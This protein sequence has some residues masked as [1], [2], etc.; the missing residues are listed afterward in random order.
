MEMYEDL[1]FRNFRLVTLFWCLDYL[2]I[3]SCYD[4]LSA[5]LKHLQMKPSSHMVNNAHC[6][7]FLTFKIYSEKFLAILL[8][9]V[10]QRYKIL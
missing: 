10:I 3:V 5:S 9:L 7:L 4:F 8:C 2:Q 6:F 1:R